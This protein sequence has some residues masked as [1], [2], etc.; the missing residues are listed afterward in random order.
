M[1]DWRVRDAT[2]DDADACAAIY[3]PYVRDTAIS[4]ELVPPD[5]DEL[6]RRIAAAQ[7]GHAWLVATAPDDDRVVGYAYGST[8]RTREAYRHSCEVSVYLEPGLRRGGAGRALYQALLPRL[9]ARGLRLALAGM[10]LPNEAS[11]GLHTAL[12]FEPVGTF[13][14]VGWKHGRWHDV[15]WMQRALT[16]TPDAPPAD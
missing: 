6:A 11:V 8:F 15:A 14:R 4:F 7:V 3:A 13:R 2:A 16:D 12:G 9:A 10:A 1:T 5:A